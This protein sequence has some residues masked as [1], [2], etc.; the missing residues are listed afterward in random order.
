[1]G[2]R[3]VDE[4]YDDFVILERAADVG[5]TWNRNRY[6]GCECDVP[7]ALYSFSFEFKTD[8]SK[9]YGTQPEILAYMQGIA[10][11]YGLR[12]HCRLGDGVTGARWNPT[13]ATWTLTL[14]SGRAIEAGVIVERDRDVQRLALARHRGPRLV[15]GRAVAFRAMGL[16]PRLERRSRRG[17]RQRGQRGAVRTRDREVR[18]PSASRP[19]HAELGAPEDRRPLHARAARR[20]PVRSRAAARVPRRSRAQ[21]EPRHDVLRSEDAGRA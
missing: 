5:G 7:S 11:T 2:K 9:P 13:T 8:W 12:P 3:L 17:D 15:R 6:P 4:G 18:T 14:D 1:M 20:L 19:A 16:E 10:D 21:H